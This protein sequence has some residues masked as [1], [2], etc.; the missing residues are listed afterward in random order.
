MFRLLTEFWLQYVFFFSYC[1]FCAPR[2]S[3]QTVLFPL[4]VC[5]LT[6][7]CVLSTCH[8]L[9]SGPLTFFLVTNEATLANRFLPTPSSEGHIFVIFSCLYL[10]CLGT[11]LAFL[12]ESETGRLL[13][14]QQ[15]SEEAN[16]KKA[17]ERRRVEELSNRIKGEQWDGEHL[18]YS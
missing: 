15:E 18:K 9:G 14:G 13:S 6:T 7:S 16:T 4:S 10:P 17:S 12:S 3:H 5:V 1:T 2:N 8:C 11:L